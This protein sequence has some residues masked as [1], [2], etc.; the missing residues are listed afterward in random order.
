MLINKN[1]V[2]LAVNGT[3]MRGLALEKN[4]LE[5]GS[6]F[7]F[8]TKTDCCYQLWS[9]NDEHPAMLRTEP[10]NHK[11][12]KVE[13]EVWTVP[14]DGLASILMKEPE[15]LSIG[16]VKLENGEVVL[17]VIGE[18]ELVKGMKEITEYG[19]WRNYINSLR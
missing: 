3:L 4:L 10:R 1:E 6:K 15:G 17:G 12:A 8:V 18:A 9:I 7:N 5:V 16:K 14:A 19:G 11:A 2:L 13:V